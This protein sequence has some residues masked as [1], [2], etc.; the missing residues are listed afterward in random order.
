MNTSADKISE[1]KTQSVANTFDEFQEG[2]QSALQFVDDRPEAVAQRRLK[3]IMN[4]SPQVVAQRTL[5]SQIANPVLQ[6]I[7]EEEPLQAKFEGEPVQFEVVD[8]APSL[9][10]NTGLPDHLKSGIENLSGYSMDDVKVHYNSDKPAQL[11]A[12]AYAQG[13]DI[14]IASGQEKYLSHEA[15]HVVQ[16]KQGRVSPTLQMKQG[17]DIND[18]ASLEK[19]ADIM[20]ARSLHITELVTQKKET[21]KGA[22]QLGATPRGIVQRVALSKDKL[23]VIG[24]E[25][26]E[27]GERR[28]RERVYS[29]KATG[30][31]NYE[32]EGAFK[33]ADGHRA[34]P[35]GLRFLYLWSRAEKNGIGN[36]LTA[37][38]CTFDTVKQQLAQ[39]KG[40]IAATGI[41]KGYLTLTSSLGNGWENEVSLAKK[42]NDPHK[43]RVVAIND[44]LKQ[45]LMQ[46]MDAIAPHQ[47]KLRV[48]YDADYKPDSEDELSD[49]EDDLLVSV[50]QTGYASEDELDDALNPIIGH[51]LGLFN[52]LQIYNQTKVEFGL[53]NEQDVANQRSKEMH[54]Q[55]N[56]R[57]DVLGVWKVGDMHRRQMER[58]DDKEYNLV[59]RD[60]FNDLL[61][62]FDKNVGTLLGITT[63]AIIGGVVGGPLGAFLGGVAGALFGR[64]AGYFVGKYRNGVRNIT[65][66]TEDTPVDWT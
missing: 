43:D 29:A 63:G 36:E 37:V 56:L 32:Q 48:H 19:E 38:N 39:H 17:V 47:E 66:G 54:A 58:M 3:A 46:F 57:S 51:G 62:A 28:D 30:S 27:S 34:D 18:D 15:W 55:A 8:K 64:V 49:N 59:S 11:Q 41:F 2:G 45:H 9:P 16:Q 20:G 10:N 44:L 40:L 12:H 42:A 23:N 13:A 6:F 31:P 33:R 24:E 22:Q 50:P 14:H 5:Q 1:S 35:S 7:K 25:H 65:T 60:A 53:G 4:N 52:A 26:N 21:S 61:M